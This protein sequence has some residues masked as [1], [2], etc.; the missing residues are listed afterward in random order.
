MKVIVNV[1]DLDLHDVQNICK[2]GSH[3][4]HVMDHAPSS[5]VF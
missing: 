2:C 3:G 5:Y 1:S 4:R